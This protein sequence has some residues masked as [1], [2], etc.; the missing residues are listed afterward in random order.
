MFGI[1]T[2]IR[3]LKRK[4]EHLLFSKKYDLIK[5]PEIRFPIVA[6]IKDDT[7]EPV[8]VA[9]TYKLVEASRTNYYHERQDILM[10]ENAQVSTNSD[11]VIVGNEI[12]WDKALFTNFTQI[13]PLDCDLGGY[14][15]DNA[16][17]VHARHIQQ[18]SG[19]CLSLL[20][21]HAG[22]WAHFL[23][24]F[25]PK[26]YL[27]AQKGLLN[28]PIT[29]IMPAY[30][31]KNILQI[32][33]GC[34]S[35]YGKNVTVLRAEPGTRYC[36]QQLF[37]IP[38]TTHIGNHAIFEL[39][40]DCVIPEYVLDL[41]KSQLVHPLVEKVRNNPTR[42]EKLYLV[43]RGTVRCMNNW[44]EVEQLFASKGFLL[45]EPH[46]LTL[47]EKADLFYHARVIVGPYSAAWSNTMF[48]NGAKGLMFCNMSR[49]I[50]SYHNTMGESLG[51]MDILQVTGWDDSTDIHTSFTIPLERIEAAYKQ[52]MNEQDN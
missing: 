31:D 41:L 36:C 30:Q 39:T 28:E 25:L 23:V 11:I 43:R 45:I 38:T 15:Q 27:A 22:I 1:L 20:G 32:I 51:H 49:F 48:A 16:T 13:V 8:Y 18:V 40:C 19:R 42:Y 14:T 3:R 47:E 37:Y 24:Q 6:H 7:W 52:L 5:H 21:V 9:A 33:D 34:L 12:L 2:R 46:K 44:Q 29:I 17:V 35:K 4:L 26:L 10:V 50:D